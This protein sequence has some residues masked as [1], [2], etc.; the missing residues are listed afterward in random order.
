MSLHNLKF[1]TAMEFQLRESA[2]QGFVKSYRAELDEE[3]VDPQHTMLIA[4]P[5]MKR[6]LEHSDII[7][8]RIVVCFA[9]LFIKYFEPADERREIFYFSSRSERV[10][11]NYFIED[12]LDRCFRKILEG[13]DNFIRNGSGW[14]ILHIK[15]IDLNIGVY[16]R[17]LR[18]G[19]AKIELPSE[20]KRKKCIVNINC[21]DE[22]CFLHCIC[23][24]LYTK[25][26]KIKNT[27]KNKFFKRLNTSRLSFPVAL[28]QIGPFA[29]QNNLIIN[30]YGYLRKEIY[31]IKMM[32]WDEECK[33]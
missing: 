16:Y 32:R 4:K 2:H 29:R 22:K 18:G 19:C 6:L 30:V 8:Q 17:E 3:Y 10:L 23:A 31:P 21:S 26:K 11:S 14:S 20:L 5:L 28:D 27:P 24:K 33:R 9:I 15:Q 12:A 25:G 7:R 13:I 1:E